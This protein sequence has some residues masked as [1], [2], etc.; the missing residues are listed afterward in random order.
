MESLV[1]FILASVG[2]TTIVVY[3][4]LFEPIR[5][6]FVMEEETYEAIHTK[7]IRPTIKQRLLLFFSQLVHCPLCFGFWMSVVMYFF[8]YGTEDYSVL[9]HFAYACAG[10]VTSYSLKSIIK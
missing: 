9:L 10:S 2:A 1:L 6:L 8:V 5:N 7:Q 3:S 4:S